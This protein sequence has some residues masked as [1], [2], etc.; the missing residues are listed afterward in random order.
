M[1]NSTPANF[2]VSGRVQCASA[3][4]DSF[5]VRVDNGSWTMLN[6]LPNGTWT[7]AN[8]GTFNLAAGAHTLYIGYREDGARLDKISVS[9]YQFTPSGTGDPAAVLCP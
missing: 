7:W 1:T 5:W 9:D 2:L 3:D 4:D 8:F 6:G